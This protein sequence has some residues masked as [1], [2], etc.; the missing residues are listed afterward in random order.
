MQKDFITV[1]PDSGNGTA[2]VMV[3]A[4]KNT[5]DVRSTSLSVSGE[6]MNRTININQAEVE[7]FTAASAPNGVYILSTDKFVYKCSVWDTTNNSKA[8]GVDVKTA[9][10]SF[11]IAPV[12]Q[13]AIQWGGYGTLISG[14]TNAADLAS[15]KKRL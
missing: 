4:V 2:T 11:V 1:T 15:A 5:G 14:C 12:E 13:T 6:G 3:A 8:V 9:K 10:C 7:R